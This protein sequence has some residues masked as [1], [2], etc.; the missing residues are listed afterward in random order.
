MP[1]DKAQARLVEAMDALGIHN[2]VQRFE[3]KGNTIT[4]WFGGYLHPVKYT[5]KTKPA[6]KRATKASA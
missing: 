3:L 5:K 6:A 2:P 1:T 4:I